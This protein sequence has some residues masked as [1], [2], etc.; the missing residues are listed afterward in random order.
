[1]LKRCRSDQTLSGRA[2]SSD[3]EKRLALARLAPADV[4]LGASVPLWQRILA[5]VSQCSQ[6]SLDLGARFLG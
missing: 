1:M 2:G 5:R 4:F 6:R 3:R